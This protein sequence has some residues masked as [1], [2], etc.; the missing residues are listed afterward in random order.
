MPV[1]SNPKY[2]SF[3]VSRP[4]ARGIDVTVAAIIEQDG[5]FLMVEERSG[6]SLVLNQPAGHLEHGESLLAAVAREALEETAHHFEPTHIVG[7]YL[8]R[9]D[10]SGVTYLRV[11]FCG[12]SG[13]MA[14]V[15]TLDEGIVGVHWLTRAQLLSRQQQLRSPMVLRCID[16]YLRGH[17]HP[18]D[19]LHYLD[20]RTLLL[21]Q[22]AHA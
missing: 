11:A 18:L 7:F 12:E 5:R 16:D 22:A 4:P 8:W 6:S 1:K 19:C 9:S 10:E 15:E 13:P 21:G 3:K 2:D 17:R 14:D 20:P